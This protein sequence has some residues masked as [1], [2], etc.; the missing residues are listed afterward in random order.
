[1]QVKNFIESKPSSGMKKAST[2]LRIIALEVQLRI[3]FQSENVKLI[4]EMPETVWEAKR[5]NPAEIFQ[6]IDGN[7]QEP[8]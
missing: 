5:K 1:M 4:R 2:E 7:C 8:S 3:Y 6:A